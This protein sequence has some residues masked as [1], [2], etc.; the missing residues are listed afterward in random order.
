MRL[1]A[2]SILA[3]FAALAAVVL[4]LAAAA[5]AQEIAPGASVECDPSGIGNYRFGT[6][7]EVLDGGKTVKLTLRDYGQYGDPVTC[8]ASTLRLVPADA[9]AKGPPAA[10]AVFHPGDRVE[11]AE[12]PGMPVKPG[13]IVGI[14][15]ARGVYNVLFD[16]TD[17]FGK[18][19]TCETATMKMFSGAPDGLRG[20]V[21]AGAA[22][23]S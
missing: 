17:P 20:F 9:F 16:D 11:C 18:A 13:S 5:C 2:S 14:A 6:V 10:F 4:G 3:G 23:T 22:P 21:K 19:L 15:D 7:L 1:S 12:S 8:A